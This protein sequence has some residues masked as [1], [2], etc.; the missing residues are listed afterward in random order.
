MFL[1]FIILAP[2]GVAEVF[3]SPLVDY[4]MVALG[5]ALPLVEVATGVHLGLHT[6][7]SAVLAMTLVMVGTINR[8]R[9]LRRRLLGVPI[10]L[11]FHLVL[12]GTWTSTA[13]FWWP[14]GGVS[15]RSVEH[16]EQSMPLVVLVGAELV[17]LGVGV[18]A[19]R[20][21]QLSEPK[22]RVLLIR[23]GHLAR[24]A[25]VGSP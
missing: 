13:L 12:D 11:F 6:L 4:R 3:K 5:A 1:W 21:Y 15:L 25:M 18:W 20:R 17:A 8:S 19:W 24:T 16:P 7:V 10:G 22:H 9:L 14:I 23:N 2:V